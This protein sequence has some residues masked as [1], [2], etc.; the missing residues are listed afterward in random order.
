MLAAAAAA[1]DAAARAH[2]EVASTAKK[3]LRIRF[4][5]FCFFCFIVAARRSVGYLVLFLPLASRFFA[6]D[7]DLL[8]HPP[9]PPTS[10]LKDGCWDAFKAVCRTRM[11]YFFW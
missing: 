10:R 2:G 6:P 5:V 3:T 7:F 9:P 4:L 1:A 11:L 8:S